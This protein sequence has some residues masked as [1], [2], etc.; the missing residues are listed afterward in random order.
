MIVGIDLAG[1]EKRPTGIALL[2]PT[3]RARLLFTDEE[4]LRACEGAELVAIDAPLSLPR[5]GK[6]RKGDR[7]L[8]QIG[9]RVF[10]P[11]FSGM[12]LLTRRGM[13]LAARLRKKTKVIEVHPRTSGLILF[14][15]GERERWVEELREAGYPLENPCEHEI[16]AALAAF[17]GKLWL[18][19][20]TRKVGNIV[21][22]QFGARLPR[23]G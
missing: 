11:L 5:K 13:R 3:L 6:L 21:I 12:R 19:G 14:G 17:T 1:D 10:P 2:G 4:I 23:P 20:K 15:T 18:E 8:I 9:F 7:E 22:P 16:D